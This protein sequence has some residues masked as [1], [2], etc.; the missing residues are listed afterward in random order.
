MVSHSGKRHGVNRLAQSRGPYEDASTSPPFP[1]MELKARVEPIHQ[2]EKVLLK[3][4]RE[5][6]ECIHE[7]QW[8]NYH[9][10]FGRMTQITP[11]ANKDEIS[12]GTPE[13]LCTF[14]PVHYLLT[15]RSLRL[16][17]IKTRKG[18]SL[19]HKLHQ[20]ALQTVK[21]LYTQYFW[22]RVYTDGSSL[23]RSGQTGAEY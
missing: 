21:R 15:H 1:T 8:E 7:N 23:P 11:T 10:E 14:H 18:N 17:E 13:P 2:R 5:R 19:S 4:N 22:L 20:L 16:P 9:S 12:S 6:N 3:N